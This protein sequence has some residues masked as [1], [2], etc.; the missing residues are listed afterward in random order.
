M[1]AIYGEILETDV[2]VYEDN[3]LRVTYKPSFIDD[4]SKIVKIPAAILVL[5]GTLIIQTNP[6]PKESW[7][8]AQIYI[9]V[10]SEWARM[11]GAEFLVDE[12][13]GLDDEFNEDEDEDISEDIV[14]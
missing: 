7:A 3:E 1:I 9:W 5:G 13:I 14:Y 4:F 6:M 11:N 10:M 12:V 2:S 8:R